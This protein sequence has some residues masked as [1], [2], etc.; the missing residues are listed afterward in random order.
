MKPNR[1]GA[2]DIDKRWEESLGGY[3]LFHKGWVSLKFNCAATSRDDDEAISL[4][5]LFR[6]HKGNVVAV[7]SVMIV[8]YSLEDAES[9]EL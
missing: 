6:D 4:G 8:G 9:L 1:K 2:G 3:R 5:V 7:W